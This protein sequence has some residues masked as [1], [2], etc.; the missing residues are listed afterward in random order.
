[1]ETLINRGIDQLIPVGN[2]A[3]TRSD[4]GVAL[5]SRNESGL[6]ALPETYSL[7][8][9]IDVAAKTDA[10]NIRLKCGA[11]QVIFNWEQNQDKL[12]IQDPIVGIPYEAEDNPPIGGGKG[13]IST[14]EF[15]DITWII[16]L[17]YMLVQVNGEN[18]LFRTNE[19]YMQFK[20]QAAGLPPC[21]IGIAPAFGSVV[22]VNKF[23]VTL[24]N[25][26]EHLDKP[27]A[28]LFDQP[29]IRMQPNETFTLKGHVFPE[30]AR[31]KKVNWSV[32]QDFVSLVGQSDGSVAIQTSEEGTAIVKGYTEEGRLSNVCHVKSV[33]PNLKT[34][35][36][37]LKP[38]SG[39]WSEELDG[40]RGQGKGDIF[41]V[42][43]DQIQNFV[44]E[45]DVVLEE[46]CCVALMFRKQ[47]NTH[48]F[49]CANIAEG[50]S[51]K[52]WRPGKDLQVVPAD[53]ERNQTYHLKVEVRED[54]I[55]VYLDGTL[56]ID[57]ED[58]TYSDGYL[59]LNVF[60][61]KGV[62][63]HLYYQPL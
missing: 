41:M 44:Y 31:N 55:Q 28:L 51:M 56:M 9:R 29:S 58:S 26:E 33:I 13:R 4:E 59:G 53:I 61:G 37:Q 23:Q 10:N 22:T 32:D 27:L 35:L 57:V 54:H 14:G 2:I 11:G 6:A 48:G 43:S 5:T 46:G 42:S 3:M 39:Y 18:R 8:L 21:M 34:N 20:K 12:L 24:W 15:V 62:F 38:L 47:P 16:D 36:K 25:H 1:M 7:P 63:Q 49:Y 19:P 45:S 52:L 50:G 30:T 40:M 17:D 60:E